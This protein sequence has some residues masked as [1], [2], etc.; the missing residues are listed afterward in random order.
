MNVK[1]PSPAGKDTLL[2]D[3][4]VVAAP[5]AAL[6][7]DVHG[8]LVRA[9]RLVVVVGDRLVLRLPADSG[10]DRQ[11]N[12]QEK[13]IKCQTGNLLQAIFSDFFLL[14]LPLHGW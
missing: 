4:A 13:M 6:V 5:P 9:P 8:A 10:W 11:T 1:S 2:C 3:K 14:S 7:R 12:R